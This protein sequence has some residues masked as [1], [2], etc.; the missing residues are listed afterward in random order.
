[1]EANSDVLHSIGILASIVSVL[2]IMPLKIRH[3]VDTLT[4]I[5]CFDSSTDSVTQRQH[6]K[7]ILMTYIRVCRKRGGGK[8]IQMCPIS[9][10]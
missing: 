8:K 7:Q 6:L 9:L 5:L 10:F 1:M 2:I 4:Y 3:V